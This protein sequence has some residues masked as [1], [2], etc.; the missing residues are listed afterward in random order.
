MP[1]IRR[2]SAGVSCGALDSTGRRAVLPAPAGDATTSAAMTEFARLPD[3][4]VLAIGGEDRVAFLQGLVSNDV[5]PAAPGRAV[6]AALLTPQGKWLADFFILADG[7]AAAARL[8]A[9][10]GA[11]PAAQRLARYRLRSRVALADARGPWPCTWRGT[12]RRT[13]TDVHRRRPTRGC[14]RRAGACSPPRPLP[15]DADA[16]GVGRASARA[17]PAGRLA[18]PGAGEDRAAG[19]RIRRA[20]RRVLEQGL[21]H[22][23]GAD[24][25]DEISRPGQAPAGAGGDRRA[26]AG[27]RHAGPRATDAEVGTMRS[28]A[29]RHGARPAAAGRAGAAARP[30][31]RRR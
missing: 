12:A 27:P 8:R 5:A 13:C 6:W 2:D 31:A 15:G 22:G 21:L 25:A 29:R 7:D 11:R 26:G 16:D 18:R 10:G 3:R 28:G 19:G 23:P 14:R 1:H 9:R 24:R 30:A 17:R 20:G 4:G